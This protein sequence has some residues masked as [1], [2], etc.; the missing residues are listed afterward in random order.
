VNRQDARAKLDTVVMDTATGEKLA[1]FD[2]AV[3]P[4]PGSIFELGNPNRDAVVRDV[5]LRVDGLI[6]VYVDVTAGRV[7]PVEPRP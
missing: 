3:W 7:P 1:H 2:G 4:R 5:R 6:T